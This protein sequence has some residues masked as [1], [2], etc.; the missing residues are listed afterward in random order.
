MMLQYQVDSSSNLNVKEEPTDTFVGRNYRFRG[1]GR[2][3]LPISG[4]GGY[5]DRGGYRGVQF[6]GI[7]RGGTRGN[8]PPGGN[9]GGRGSMPGGSRN[10]VDEA[11]RNTKCF[12][13]KSIFHWA[14]E[15]P[16]QS[17]RRDDDDSFFEEE[18]QITLFAKGVD[19]DHNGRLLG[20]TIGCAVLDS[21]CTRNV[22][23]ES[24]LD[25][26]IESLNEKERQQI[27]YQESTRK[28]RFGDNKVYDSK[29]CVKIPA[30]IGNRDLMI[31]T[32]VISNDVPLLLS[33]DAMKRANTVIKFQSDEVS[34]FGKNINLKFTTSGH[35]AIPISK[36]ASVA[37]QDEES[38]KPTCV[39]FSNV[40]KIDDADKTEKMKMCVKI[41]KQFSH[42][43][44]KRLKKLLQDGGILDK[45]MLKIMETIHERCNIC[46]K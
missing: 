32:D 28:F 16:H 37:H 15:C 5:R 8:P 4:R 9:S 26:Y 11:G 35:Y 29:T 40:K 33:K 21:G 42:A 7:G 43:N 13:C 2:S 14:R 38:E 24:W 45:E 12:I 20:E 18:V 10:P 17:A 41:H 36:N 22:C 19:S 34:M 6:R 30:H 44:G 3:G 23:S 39:Y 25:C 46:Q 1:R 31:E 27:S